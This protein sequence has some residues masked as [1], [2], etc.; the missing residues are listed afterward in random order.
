MKW[1]ESYDIRSRSVKLSYDRSLSTLLFAICIV[2]D[3]AKCPP[4]N[5]G[6]EE[7]THYCPEPGWSG[8]EG[9]RSCLSWQWGSK[10]PPTC[11]PGCHDHNPQAV[12]D[13]IAATITTIVIQR[14]CNSSF[15]GNKGKLVD[16][17]KYK[18]M[19][20]FKLFRI[21]NEWYIII[22]KLYIDII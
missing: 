5:T 12:S 3:G 18:V 21:R 1:Q 8:V 22:W 19:K 17:K 2:Q 14:V 20:L 9:R 11:T 15:T 13:A 6:A 7:V 4:H 10:C 16:E